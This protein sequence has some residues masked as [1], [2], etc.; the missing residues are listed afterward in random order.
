M[1]GGDDFDGCVLTRAAAAEAGV[2]QRQSLRRR[3]Q[4]NEENESCKGREAHYINHITA[5]RILDS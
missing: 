5:R 2:R 4:T 1:T 3:T